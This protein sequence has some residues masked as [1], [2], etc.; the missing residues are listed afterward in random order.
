MWWPSHQ[1]AGRSQPGISQ[2]PPARTTR[3]R[4][5]AVL[6][7]RRARPRSRVRATWGHSPPQSDRLPNPSTWWAASTSASPCRAPWCARRAPRRLP[8]WVWPGRRSLREP[9]PP[10]RRRARRA[11]CTGP[12]GTG[13][14]TGCCRPRR[15]VGIHQLGA[16]SVRVQRVRHIPGG[17]DDPV[18]TERHADS[19][20]RTNAAVHSVSMPVAL[21]NRLRPKS[22]ALTCIAI[23]TRK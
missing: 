16:A 17:R 14:S 1:E 4:R 7:L 2:Y 22:L 19:T 3:A 15:L 6:R 10:P 5:S 18:T 23:A 12:A 21:T 20:T 8:G 13:R 11:A 9:R